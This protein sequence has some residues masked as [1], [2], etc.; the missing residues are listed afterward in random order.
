MKE[1]TPVSVEDNQNNH[2]MLDELGG[3]D[4]DPAFVTVEVSENGEVLGTM[5]LQGF[6]DSGSVG[7]RHPEMDEIDRALTVRTDPEIIPEPVTETPLE[8]KKTSRRK[9]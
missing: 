7:F 9:L 5:R 6:V 1:F 4:I 8:P 3:S 2:Y